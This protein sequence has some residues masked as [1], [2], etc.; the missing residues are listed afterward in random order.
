MF[1]VNKLRQVA[2]LHENQIISDNNRSH[3]STVRE[4]RLSDQAVAS[5]NA[6]RTVLLQTQKHE[7]E[8][9]EAIESFTA[10]DKDLLMLKASSQAALTSL[11]SSFSIL[12]N[13]QRS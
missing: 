8:M 3:Q 5:M 6:V 7:K 10:T 13:M 12:Q 1:W 9:S 4:P 2:L 11:Q